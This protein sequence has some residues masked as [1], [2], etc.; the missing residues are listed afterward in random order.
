MH[1]ARHLRNRPD[2][3]VIS[4]FLRINN[5]YSI[6]YDFEEIAGKKK[7]HKAIATCKT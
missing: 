4:F 1:V 2:N 6:N 3:V 7:T 5:S